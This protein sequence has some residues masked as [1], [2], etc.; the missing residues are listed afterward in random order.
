MIEVHLGSW[1]ENTFVSYRLEQLGYDWVLLITGG[2]SHIGSVACS[3]KNRASEEVWQI[4]LGQHKEENIVKNAVLKLKDILSG[5][6]LVVGGIH[7]DNL[8][9]KQI[10]Q[11]EKNC[12]A[13]LKHL[14]EIII[15]DD[16]RNRT[17][18]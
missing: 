16:L 14:E 8:S 6:I 2:K 12:E 9:R 3:E 15:N 17:Y 10:Q 5:E 11:I 1:E 13:L 18:L 4:T 7:Y